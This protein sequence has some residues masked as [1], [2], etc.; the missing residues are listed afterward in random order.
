MHVVIWNAHWETLGGGEF[1]AGFLAD[2]LIKDKYSVTLVG[3]CNNPIQKLRDRLG[4]SLNDVMYERIPGE[5]FLEGVVNEKDIFINGSFGSEVK[6]PSDKSVYI[7]HFPT[8]SR[9]NKLI[10]KWFVQ[11]Y[12]IVYQENGHILHPINQTVLLIG[13]GYLK[14]TQAHHVRIR[15]EFGAVTIH[16]KQA[17]TIFL[18]QGEEI[19]V[20]VDGILRIDSTGSHQPVV[21]I[22]QLPDL[23]PLKRFLMGK[24]TRDNDFLKTYS[25]IWTNS[26]FTKQHVSKIWQS[27]SVVVY[28]PHLNRNID[29]CSRDQY[30]ILSIGRFMDRREGHS[31]NQ[32]ELIRAFQKLAKSKTEPW[33]LHLVGGVDEKNTKYFKRVKKMASKN[34]RVFLYPNCSGDELENLL[35]SST[36]Y[37]HATGMKIPAWKP[38]KMEHFGISVLEALNAGLVPVVFNSAGPAEILQDFPDLRFNKI[39]ELVKKTRKLSISDRKFITEALERR[40]KEFDGLHFRNTVRD[41]LDKLLNT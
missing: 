25:Q 33:S 23:K 39:N 10:A 31:K 13:K 30:A 16:G 3:T 38:E 26:N 18:S 14:S 27:D 11:K 5:R 6:S 40:G 24:G 20:V 32:V 22:S 34:N 35:H 21:T 29:M 37:W 7:C 1:Y 2:V 8:I 19:N 9:R 12:C 36:F 17:S 28:P 15:C 41:Q 4:L